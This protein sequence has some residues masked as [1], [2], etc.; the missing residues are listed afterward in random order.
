MAAL[1]VHH[2]R[3]MIAHSDRQHDRG[4]IITITSASAGEGKTSL[5]LTLG[6]SFAA[7][8]RNTLMIDADLVGRGLTSQFDLLRVPGLTEVKGHGTKVEEVIHTTA[9]ENLSV[10]PAGMRLDF[11]PKQLSRDGSSRLLD[12]LRKIY[13]PILIDTGPILGSLEADIVCPLADMV[14]VGLSRGTSPKIAQAALARLQQLN[15]QV[16]GIVFNRASMQDLTKS[17]SH[18]SIHSQSMRSQSTPRNTR[19]PA[20]PLALALSTSTT[21]ES[22]QDTPAEASAADSNRKTA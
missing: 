5:T 10:L 2:I 3:N 4:Q 15:A 21:D 17:V 1:S 9:T 18:V 11:D 13:D 16:A 8:G 14:V 19:R 20:A 6:M 7:T 12:E 22:V